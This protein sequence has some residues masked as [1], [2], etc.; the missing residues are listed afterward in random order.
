MKARPLYQHIASALT[1][2]ENCKKSGNSMWESRWEGRLDWIEKNLLPRGSGFDAGTTI[3]LDKCSEDKIVLETAFHH[4]DENGSYDGW[5]EHRVTITPSLLHGFHMKVGGRNVND[6]KEYIEETL[7]HCL[8]A[9]YSSEELGTSGD[10]HWSALMG[11]TK[12]DQVP[13]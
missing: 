8:D 7:G 3:V 10:E 13:A 1:A 6:I 2:L 4:M 9:E 12:S 5:S 11:W